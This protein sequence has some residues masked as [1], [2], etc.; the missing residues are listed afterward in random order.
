MSEK[1]KFERLRDEIAIECVKVDMRSWNMMSRDR[2][3]EVAIGWAKLYGKDSVDI[4]ACL[5]Q[6]AYK[7]ADAMIKAKG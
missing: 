7:M 6:D 2:K 3:I 4:F 1:E 5:A